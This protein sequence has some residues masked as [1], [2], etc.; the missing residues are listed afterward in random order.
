MPRLNIALGL[1]IASGLAI[2]AAWT[3][4]RA[5]EAGR[6]LAAG[7]D[8]VQLTDLALDRGFDAAV[9]EREIRAALAGN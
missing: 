7:N 3:L 6:T 9:A 2:A 4:P 8:P 1:L 5:A